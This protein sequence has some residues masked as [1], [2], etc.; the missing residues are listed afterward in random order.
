MEFTWN[1]PMPYINFWETTL[2]MGDFDCTKY[3]LQAI[4]TEIEDAEFEEITSDVL[5]ERLS[6]PDHQA[7][8]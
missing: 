2:D 8:D 4:C 5:Q 1:D 6:Q 7:V 3:K